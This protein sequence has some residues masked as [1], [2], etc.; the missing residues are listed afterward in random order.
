M[1]N[2][3]DLSVGSSNTT[4][5]SSSSCSS[6][7]YCI[8]FVSNS[9]SDG[10]FDTD[11]DGNG[12]TEA[13]DLC[14]NDGNKPTS[15]TYKAMIMDGTN[16]VACTSANCSGGV[17]EH[18]D[19]VLKTS[20]EYRR[21]DET[22]VIGTTTSNGIFNV[23][24]PTPT[25]DNAIGTVSTFVWTGLAGDWTSNNDCTNWTSTAGT[26]TNG[27]AVNTN[28]IFLFN[29]SGDGCSNTRVVYCVEQ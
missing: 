28:N 4:T 25:L 29:N 17:S 26:G 12:I 9:T 1:G 23:G 14:T 10:D 19:W 16:R 8:I 22:T 18:T 6:N 20:Q 11:N 24:L 15:G 27:Q 2:G 7:G 5:S 3:T 13:D 21:T